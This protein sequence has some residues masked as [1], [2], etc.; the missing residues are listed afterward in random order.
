MTTKPKRTKPMDAEQLAKWLYTRD[1]TPF[2]SWDDTEESVHE[3]WLDL[4]T[5]VLK[6]ARRGRL[7]GKDMGK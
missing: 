4:A 1:G 2:G 7:P 5:E 6:L 3:F